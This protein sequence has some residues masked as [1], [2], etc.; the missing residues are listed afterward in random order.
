[1]TLKD[2]H[3]RTTII[4]I[5]RALTPKPPITA[6]PYWCLVNTLQFH[7][8]KGKVVWEQ[9][10][11]E[12]DIQW[13]NKNDKY[14]FTTY[15][16]CSVFKTKHFGWQLKCTITHEEA[17]KWHKKIMDYIKKSHKEYHTK[18]EMNEP[19]N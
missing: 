17:K 6:T 12:A 18:R 16:N 8:K 2:E 13:V 10:I 19:K 7:N 9:K 15:F 14:E 5:E 4:T 1:M 3:I 11:P